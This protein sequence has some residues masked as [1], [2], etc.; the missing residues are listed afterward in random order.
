[1]AFCLQETSSTKLFQLLFRVF[2]NIG[3]DV[4]SVSTGKSDLPVHKQ[5]LS[6]FTS[7]EKKTLAEVGRGG[8]CVTCLGL[9][10]RGIRAR[11][12][13]GGENAPH[14]R[15]R[16]P[17]S[18]RL[19]GDEPACLSLLSGA[20]PPP[21]RE[22]EDCHLTLK[23]PEFYTHGYMVLFSIFKGHAGEASKY[24]RRL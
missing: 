23:D 17:R 24:G 19:L 13:S 18:R 20:T 12:L 11:D 21:K 8:A 1:M 3:F 5:F 6:H 7:L 9:R 4:L 10:T 16:H 15:E 2:I 14:S 22:R